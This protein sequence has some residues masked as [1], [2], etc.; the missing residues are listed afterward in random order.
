MVRGIWFGCDET[1]PHF[2][3]NILEDKDGMM[4]NH[5]KNIGVTFNG[6]SAKSIL[7][8]NANEFLNRPLFKKDDGKRI[9]LSCESQE[10]HFNDIS[11]PPNKAFTKI[12]Q[13]LVEHMRGR[14]FAYGFK[15]A[16]K[17]FFSL[18]M[19]DFRYIVDFLRSQYDQSVVSKTE[20]V[21]NEMVPGVRVKCLGEVAFCQSLE[22]R[23]SIFA[24]AGFAMPSKDEG[25]WDCPAAEKIGLPIVV[26]KCAPGISW[27]GR[28]FDG[29]HAAYNWYHLPLTTYNA[30]DLS[31]FEGRTITQR[32]ELVCDSGSFIVVRQDK[33]PLHFLHIQAMGDYLIGK[34]R[35][36]EK[37]C[38]RI[39]LRGDLQVYL[40]SISKDDFL[41]MWD[42]FMEE[43]KD[44]PDFPVGLEF[45]YDV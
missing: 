32:D 43:H 42:A 38:N 7:G 21:K 11:G 19:A 44:A 13:E 22:S 36:H 27:K 24:T 10:G 2:T 1:T 29:T 3:W 31:L 45:P 18:T 35:D 25:Q 34:L 9:Y 17:E 26:T 20:N 12:N 5:V 4:I 23:P 39:G 41:K 28:T 6:M 8:R 33:K 16:T 40:D 14:L 37:E 15:S 30:F